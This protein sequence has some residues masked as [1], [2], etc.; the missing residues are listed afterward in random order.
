M[1]DEKNEYSKNCRMPKS[2]AEKIDRECA[3]EGVSASW[4]M[5]KALRMYFGEKNR[6]KRPE[7]VFQNSNR[8][9]QA[10]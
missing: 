7:S 6:V 5:R 4:V 2:M 1:T 8:S 3:K 10:V 9:N